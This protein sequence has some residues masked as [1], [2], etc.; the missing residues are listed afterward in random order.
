MLRHDLISGFLLAILGIAAL[1]TTSHA[2]L[3][4]A[5]ASPAQSLTVDS[6]MGAL[7]DNAAARKI[8][9]QHLPVLLSSPQIE[10]A[11]GLSLR[12][13]QQF[14]PTV[15]TD[16]KLDAINAELAKRKV[17]GTIES[18]QSAEKAAADAARA[19]AFR[20]ALTLATIPLWEHGA[21]GAKGEQPS[22]IPDLTV[23]RPD[24]ATSFG[25]AVIVAPGGGYQ[26]LALGHEGR[27][28]ADLLAAQG[29]TAFILR[30]RLCPYGYQH[31]TQLQDAQRAI[32][33]V[34]AR[35]QE[36]GIDPHRIGMLGFSAGGHL[37]AMAS[38]LFD[39]GN[40]AAQ[41]PVD[42]MSSRPDFAILGYAPV[43]LPKS[44]TRDCFAG[45]EP[46][47][48]S[49]MEIS[50]AG[51]VSAETPPTF[52]F[53]TTSD[54]LV[55]PLN[56]TRYYDALIAAQVPAELHIF[57][58]GRHGLGLAMTDPVLAIWPTLLANWLRARNLTG[59]E[60]AGRQSLD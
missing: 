13:L 38:T 49:L 28:V 47:E 32:R 25:T 58:E 23:V 33:W 1:L 2:A 34:R 48:K 42:Q 37:T 31:P 36:Y 19:A 17:V 30:Y 6:P 52:I 54:E 60:T 18:M 16:D 45:S 35:A 41:D 5:A 40:P 11:R 57:A 21:P 22:D 44:A 27:Q 12:S 10:L 14:A 55:P 8:I 53:H 24:G 15:V 39:A 20:E 29:V 7:L 50:P 43:D 59:I 4:Q 9:Q 51:N 46:D 3:A 56:A 26:G